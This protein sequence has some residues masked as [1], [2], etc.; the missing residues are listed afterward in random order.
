MYL[1]RLLVVSGLF[2]LTALWPET[3]LAQKLIATG[4]KAGHHKIKIKNK[5]ASFTFS[6]RGKK[7]DNDTCISINDSLITATCLSA[8]NSIY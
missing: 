6:C 2:L 5:Y 8:G 1:L 3:M 4:I 7:I